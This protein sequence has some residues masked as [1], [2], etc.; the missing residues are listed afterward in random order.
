MTRRLLLLLLT[1]NFPGF[2][3]AQDMLS[4]LR[5]SATAPSDLLS[6]RSIVLYDYALT[7][8]DLEEVQ[9]AFQQIGIDAVAYFD[10][11]KVTAGVDPAKVHTAYFVTREIRYLIFLRK[12]AGVYEFIATPFNNKSSLFNKEQSAWRVSDRIL[13]DLLMTVYRDSWLV[14]KKKNL[15]INDEPELNFQINMIAGRR[16]ELYPIDLKTDNVAFLKSDDAAVQAQVDDLLS[17][18][19]PY[20]EKYKAIDSIPSNEKDLRRKEG[21]QFLLMVVHCRGVSAKDLLGYDVSRKES[22]YGSVSYT[23]GTPQVKTIPVET[24]VYKFYIKHVESGNVFLGTKWDADESMV[25][26]LKNHI[27]GLRAEFKLN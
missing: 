12:P 23:N 19:Y 27:Q 2:L 26:A 14:Q 20:P 21:I 9:N 7:K 6:T 5:F 10:M 15:L 16:S 25:Q 1:L 8:D 24:P 22:A 11:D 17:T 3:S 18:L 13:N 4:Q